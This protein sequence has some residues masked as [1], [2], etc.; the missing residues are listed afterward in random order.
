MS[1]HHSHLNTALSLIKGYNGNF[2]F[3]H[4][5]KEYF[6]EYRK[7][8]GNDRKV[9]SQL[10]YGYYRAGICLNS[11]SP[12]QQ[13]LAGFFLTTQKEHPL[14][15]AL[16]PAYNATVHEPLETKWKMLFPGK[17]YSALFPLSTALSPAIDRDAFMASMLKQ[18]RF[19]LRIR[20]GKHSQVVDAFTKAGIAYEQ[21]NEQCLALASAT[22]ADSILAIDKDAVIQDYSSQQVASLFPDLTARKTLKLWDAC[23]ASGGKSLLAVDHYGTVKLTV[24]DIRDTILHNLS[25][26]F[27]RAG[28][29]DYRSF[30]IDLSESKGTES[31]HPANGYD[32]VIADVP[33][34]GSGTWSRSPEQ[35]RYFRKEQIQ[36]Y[37]VLQQKIIRHT[38]PQVARNGYYL[39]I[40]CSVF[41]QENEAQV[42]FIRQHTPLQLV[43]KQYFQGMERGA[44]TL[45]AALF[46][47]SPQ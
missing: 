31:M 2:P 18:P 41:D 32:L 39:Y 13:L 8:G 10:C 16:Q 42:E 27:S 28:L 23:A 29:S 22:A 37:V 40:T 11:L 34:S 12:E 20:P 3:A 44:D 35:I 30:R 5:L 47:A 6:R 21:V 45:F 43:R 25:S 26:R 4:Y 36:D 33:C 17:D 19:F 9:I 14:L 38:V 1:R 24:S 46:T 15:D 7:Y